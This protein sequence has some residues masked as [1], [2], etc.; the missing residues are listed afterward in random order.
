MFEF[1]WSSRSQVNS[2]PRLEFHLTF[3]IGMRLC[4]SFLISRSM[5]SM[6]YFMKCSLLSTLISS[7][8]MCSDSSD[9]HF[10]RFDTC[11]VSWM[12]AWACKQR[13]QSCDT[14]QFR[15]TSGERTN[16]HTHERWW[17]NEKKNKTKKNI[18]S[19][20]AAR[21]GENDIS[22]AT[23]SRKRTR[24]KIVHRVTRREDPVDRVPRRK[25]TETT[26]CL[27]ASRGGIRS[28]WPRTAA[29][30]VYVKS[31]TNLHAMM[32]TNFTLNL[33]F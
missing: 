15:V 8:G 1:H 13:D 33:T 14:P 26:P 19:S 17:Q 20:S 23:R 32:N 30:P 9:R 16:T 18:K 31:F 6:G 29:D 22:R 28:S 3:T 10:L 12:F 24:R 4:L 11:K 25:A 21:G 2:G 7:M 5:I 27:I